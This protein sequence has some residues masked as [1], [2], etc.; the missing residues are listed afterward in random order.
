MEGLS[1]IAELLGEENEKRLKD[2]IVDLLLELVKND[3]EEYSRTEWMIDL[4]ELY[5]DVDKEVRKEVKDKMI[6]KYVACAEN[7]IDKIF[8][9]KFGG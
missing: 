4:D 6:K 8:E 3:I 5:Y 7:K 2:G 9:E 1:K